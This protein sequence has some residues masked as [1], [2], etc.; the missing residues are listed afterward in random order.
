MSVFQVE[1]Y[2][3]THPQ[4]VVFSNVTTMR[5]TWPPTPPPIRGKATV[6]GVQLHPSVLRKCN[7]YTL[8]LKKRDE[9]VGTCRDRVPDYVVRYFRGKVKS[10]LLKS[11]LLEF[12]TKTH[13]IGEKLLCLHNLEGFQNRTSVKPH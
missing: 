5:P 10:H 2:G 8:I 6:R 11:T 13:E 12:I 3:Q 7:F 1:V 9:Y 4:S